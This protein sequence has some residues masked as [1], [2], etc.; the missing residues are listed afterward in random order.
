MS[1]A[2]S[3]T[4]QAAAFALLIL[5]LL[6]LP[7]VMGKSSLPPREELYSAVPWATGAFPYMHDEFFGD[8][9][10]I[11]IAF[12]GSSR[13]WWDIDTPYVQDQ[14]SRQLGHKAV[15]RSYCWNWP[16]FDPLYFIMK[17]LLDHRKVHLIVFGDY[18]GGTGDTAH[19]AAPSWF[20]LG[21]NSADIAGLPMNS[22]LSFYSSAILGMPR[23]LLDLLRTNLPPLPRD[24]L[25]W[26][27]TPEGVTNLPNMV[28]PS[29]RL[30]S[31]GL[32][33]K[34]G[35]TF[36]AYTPPDGARPEDVVIYSDATAKSF[37]FSGGS[38]PAMQADFVRKVAALAREH[39]TGIVLLH[40]PL[41]DDLKAPLL[42]EP[43]FWP[44]LFH[45]NL[46]LMGVPPPK[47]F[48]GTTGQ[49]IPRLFWNSDHLNPNGQAYFTKLVTPDLLQIY[50][51]QTKP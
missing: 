50:E 24:E 45:G 16:G 51:D 3:S 14:L 43:V 34:P 6:L 8:K 46:T 37:D 30:G 2:F 49:D 18:S 10:D 21:D 36:D 19:V 15:V 29:T 31:A 20:R 41:T 11:D 28:N 25:P 32:H 48:Q 5:A 17:D 39:R 35:Q 40:L 9:E 22:K 27:W 12:L 23:N 42:E 33:L 26:T 47:F 38:I 44:D 7:A 4:R 1:P 13:M